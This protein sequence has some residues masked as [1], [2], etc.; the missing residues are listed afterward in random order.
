MK[1]A[2]H[3]T[4]ILVA[5]YS[6]IALLAWPAFTPARTAGDSAQPAD[7][8]CS[9]CIS[10]TIDLG[11]QAKGVSAELR[12][13]RSV[14][15]DFSDIHLKRL[16]NGGIQGSGYLV[17]NDSRSGLVCL[18][19][20]WQ[21]HVDNPRALP[22]SGTDSI[23][24]WETGHAFLAPGAD[25]N[26]QYSWTILPSKG[27]AVR[28][29]TGVVAY[30]EFDDGTRLGPGVATFFPALCARREKLLNDYHTLLDMIHAGRP[31][32][33]LEAFVQTTRGLEWAGNIRASKGWN[34]VAAEISRRLHPIGQ[35]D[36]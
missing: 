19:I 17:R 18:I 14:P 25:L 35:Q 13:P 30:A 9:G 5:F 7:F 33:E 15:L 20:S 23:S 32:T 16:P 27:H 21:T 10:R 4:R 8:H 31:D 34:G 36:R 11:P 26:V 6:A 24:S 3:G 12:V 29:V 2:T 1:F 22:A 28:R